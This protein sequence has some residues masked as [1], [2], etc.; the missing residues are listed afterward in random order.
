MELI[1]KTISADVR[2]K[3]QHGLRDSQLNT[4]V[5]EEVTFKGNNRHQPDILLQLVQG[6]IV[7]EESDAIIV[8]T[9]QFLSFTG[10]VSAALIR[11]GGDVI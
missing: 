11:K 1:N 8:P 4:T 5:L 10:G 7:E 3:I 9:S 6:N 2:S